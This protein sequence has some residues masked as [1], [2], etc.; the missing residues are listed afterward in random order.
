VRFSWK[1]ASFHL[2]THF[3]DQFI[4]KSFGEIDPTKMKL[5]AV[6]CLL[7]STKLEEPCQP[8]VKDFVFVVNFD[9]TTTEIIEQE[10]TIMKCLG[11]KLVSESSVDFALYLLQEIDAPEQLR[12]Y[13][14]YV[15]EVSMFS[16]LKVKVK[17]S[18]LACGAIYIAAKCFGR[19]ELMPGVL[20]ISGYGKSSVRR[21]ACRLYGMFVDGN[22]YRGVGGKEKKEGGLD[23]RAVNK[24]YA[25]EKF[26]RLSNYDLTVG[27][28]LKS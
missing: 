18:L 1:P 14:L 4:L 19:D 8:R 24:K 27:G 20:R 5:I 25:V 16:T 28:E 23:L 9:F 21:C 6:A 3:L 11:Y 15:L 13:T 26:D 10:D 17:N 7:M 12:N 2:A 22:Q